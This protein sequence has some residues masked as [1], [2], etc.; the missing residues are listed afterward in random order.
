VNAAFKA[1]CIVC[2]FTQRDSGHNFE[3]ILCDRIASSKSF[4]SSER[5]TASKYASKEYTS[6]G[7]F[8]I[9]LGKRLWKSP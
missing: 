5:N 7:Y 2:I 6:Y 1:L 3:K 8:R 9:R 4:I